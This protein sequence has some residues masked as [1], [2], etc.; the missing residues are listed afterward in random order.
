MNLRDIPCIFG[1]LE[2]YLLGLIR[3]H[4]GKGTTVHTSERISAAWKATCEVPEERGMIKDVNP[5]E[6]ERF[7]GRVKFLYK[8]C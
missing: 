8:I 7:L 6:L 4:R 3:K 1:Y 2:L 5:T